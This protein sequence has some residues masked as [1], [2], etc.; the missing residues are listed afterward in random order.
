MATISVQQA[1]E[2]F[3][4][5]MVMGLYRLGICLAISF[6]YILATFMGAGVGFAVGSSGNDPAVFA[7]IGAFVGFGICGFILYNIR[8]SLFFSPRV[9]HAALLEKALRDKSTAEKNQINAGKALV[10]ARFNNASTLFA[11]DQS[12]KSILTDL[13]FEINPI[14]RKVPNIANRFLYRIVRWFA[15]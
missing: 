2:S 6:S 12:I 14:A 15:R 1:M 4:K 13:L 5:T 11:L 9:S 8:P 3:E 7:S 10:T